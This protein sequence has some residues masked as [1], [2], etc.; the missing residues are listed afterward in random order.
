MTRSLS[1][2]VPRFVVLAVLCLA[3]YLPIAE[4]SAPRYS[5]DCT[6]YSDA[7]YTTEVGGDSFSCGR[8]YSQWGSYSD[9]KLCS[10]DC[11]S[12]CD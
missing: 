1:Q 4:A 8:Q 3:L 9:Y 11:C 7:S 5:S 10:F 6:F 2:L 12:G